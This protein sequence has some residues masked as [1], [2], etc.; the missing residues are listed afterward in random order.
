M[1]NGLR[2]ACSNHVDGLVR[3]HLLHTSFQALFFADTRNKHR[4]Q[5]PT[6]KMNFGFLGM[7]SRCYRICK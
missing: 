3:L 6:F 5:L 1:W 7:K 4:Y 2:A